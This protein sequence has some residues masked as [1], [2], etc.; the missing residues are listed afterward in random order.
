MRHR[1][2]RRK[3]LIN[4]KEQL[5]LPRLPRCCW[6][7]QFNQASND[8][9]KDEGNTH[10]A[11]NVKESSKDPSQNEY[12]EK[13][14]SR[15]LEES[16]TFNEVK[17]K[18]WS[19]SPYPE[20]IPLK[21]EEIKKKVDPSERTVFL[22]PG[23]GTIK[24][25]TIKRYIQIPLAKE[26]FQIANEILDYNL[27]KLCLDGPQEKLNRTEYNQ[28]ATVISSLAALEKIRKETPEAF[29]KCIGT[30]GYSVGEITSL[31]FSG[32]FTFEDGIRL[33]WARG[34]AMQLASDRVPQ[35]ML[36]VFC[37]P[38]AELS[39]ACKAAE[40]WARDVGIENPICRTAIFL[41]TQRKI[42]GGN[43]ETLKYIEKHQAKYG[44]TN[45]NKLPV[46]G[47][48]HTPLME[49][50]LKQVFNTLSAIEI[51]E[52]R[53]QVYSN[54]KAEPYRNLRFLKKYVLKQMVSPVRWEQCVQKLYS[55]PDG[56]P[57][58]QTYDVG[59]EGRMKTVLKLIN[60]KASNSCIVV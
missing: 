36:S 37:L 33:A 19:T 39:E 52:P 45:V 53:C 21:Q 18:S 55:R 35:G 54:Y 59:S 40:E 16:V 28:A 58:P 51:N 17:N 47:A 23:Q 5:V 15:L 38:S 26:L 50:A 7:N 30:A 25:G 13:E 34:K 49:P 22:F 29:E 4:Y 10:D 48:F 11:L 42:L 46:S 14:V 41:C 43:A 8:T 24:V 6:L 2:P 44:L 1:T 3:T 27:L 60:A 32:V 57:F 56:V 20:D 31:I 9:K 12:N